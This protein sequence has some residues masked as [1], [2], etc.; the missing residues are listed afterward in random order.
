MPDWVCEAVEA[1]EEREEEGVRLRW[2][3]GL[4]VVGGAK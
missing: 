2:V 4:V 3:V 1:S